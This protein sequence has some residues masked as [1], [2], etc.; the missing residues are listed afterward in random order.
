MME[1]IPAV[2]E[3]RAACS[4]LKI[5]CADIGFLLDILLF[6][7]EEFRSRQCIQWGF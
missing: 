3:R 5:V 1:Y 7:K 6:S 4:L 2:K